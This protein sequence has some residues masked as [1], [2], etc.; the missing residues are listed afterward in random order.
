MTDTTSAASVMLVG[1]PHA[2]KSSYIAL[3]YLA[4]LKRER[5]S[6][7]LSNHKDDREHVNLLMRALLNCEEA[8]RTEIDQSEGLRLSLRDSSEKSTFLEIPDLSG[9]TWQDVLDEGA[10]DLA[11]VEQLRR[12][13]S[14]VLF[15]HVGDFRNDPLISEVVAGADALGFDGGY[16]DESAEPVAPTQVDIAELLQTIDHFADARCEISVVLSA[17]DL[18]RGVA[19]ARWVRDNAPLVDQYV[20]SNRA[21]RPVRIYGLS[22][23]GGDFASER[24]SLLNEDG[25]HRAFMMNADGEQVDFDEPL[26]GALSV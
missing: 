14:I 17:Y 9:E 23:Q 2:G 3:L 5:C 11:L 19:P 15:L 10:I 7:R 24:T 1:L 16:E 21:R 18:A 22:A 12:A 25:L 6:V 8:T 13:R 26:V 20:R 4:I